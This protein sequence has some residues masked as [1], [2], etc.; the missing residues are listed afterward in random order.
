MAA[1]RTMNIPKKPC[2]NTI[3]MKPVAANIEFSGLL[4]SCQDILANSTGLFCI[5]HEM[6]DCSIASNLFNRWTNENR[7][8][9]GI[10]S[11]I[12]VVANNRSTRDIKKIQKSLCGCICDSIA[13]LFLIACLFLNINRIRDNIRRLVCKIGSARAIAGGSSNRSK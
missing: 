10:Q 5:T 7:L 3:L 1:N 11:R 12:C 8:E 6:T 2:I 4:F 13:L 9:K